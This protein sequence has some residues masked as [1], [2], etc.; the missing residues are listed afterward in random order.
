M[1]DRSLYMVF[2]NPAEGR[3]DD[4]NKWYDEVHIP[5]VLG[6]P[7]FL[8]AQ[9]ITQQVGDSPSPVAP[10]QRYGVLYEIEGDPAQV[11]A[12][13]NEAM[14]SGKLNMTDAVDPRSFQ[15]AFWTPGEKAVA[16]REPRP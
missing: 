16:E 5:E 13:L 12:T 9:R 3:D 10:E 6:L 8:S 7:G 11:S 1:A 15:M 14:A 4:Y 2:S